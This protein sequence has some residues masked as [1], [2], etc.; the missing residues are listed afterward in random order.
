MICM[1]NLSIPTQQALLSAIPSPDPVIEKS[2]KRN[3]LQ[4]EVPSPINTKPGCRF[5]LRCMYTKPECTQ[6]TPE[7]KEV[8]KMHFVACHL[9]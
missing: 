5:A 8:K 1:R 6:F 4:G 9:F 2:R 3:M 7:F